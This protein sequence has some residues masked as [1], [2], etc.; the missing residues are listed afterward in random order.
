MNR[1][2]ALFTA[3]L[4][5][6][7]ML[8]AAAQLRK[9]PAEV[10]EAFKAKYAD[11]KNVEWKDKLS[12]FEADYEMNGAQYRSRFSN[13]G[14]WQFTEKDL[15]DNS[16]PAPVKDGFGKSKYADW[17]TKTT[18]WIE[19]S[20][21]TVQYRLFVRKSSVEKRYLLFDK[22]GRLLKDSITL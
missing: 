21:N 3:V 2:V 14:E 20:D 9:V 5:T 15:D 17:E 19:N 10:T 18:T 13:K 22:D 8:P 1:I 11:T 4:F 12:G 16:L 7:A 6:L